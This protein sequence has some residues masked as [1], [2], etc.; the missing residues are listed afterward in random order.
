MKT[1]NLYFKNTPEFRTNYFTRYASG[2]NGFSSHFSFN[3]QSKKFSIFSGIT[4]RDYGDVKMGRNRSHG[5]E[6]W[7]RIYYY[8]QDG[9]IVENTNLDIQPNT[10]YQQL[11]WIN[12]MM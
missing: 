1:K 4:S 10:G 11:D 8:E 6:D 7:G 2:Y 12:K 5:Y 9:D 3:Y